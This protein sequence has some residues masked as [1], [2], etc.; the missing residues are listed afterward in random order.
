MTQPPTPDANPYPLVT[1]KSTQ[2]FRDKN[3]ILHRAW[4]RKLQRDAE[5]ER[6]SKDAQ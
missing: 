2:L 4:M 3:P 1:D 6:T 5:N